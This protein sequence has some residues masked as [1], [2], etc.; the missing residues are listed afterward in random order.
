MIENC[1]LCNTSIKSLMSF[2][3]MPIAN[4][5]RDLNSDT[6]EFFYEMS[7]GFCKTCF[8]FQLLDNPAPEIN[9]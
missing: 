2:G 8:S 9:V 7:V 3:K 1:R 5:F 6:N 4:G